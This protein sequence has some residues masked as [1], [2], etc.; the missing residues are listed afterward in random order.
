MGRESV[1]K[2]GELAIQ[3]HSQHIF[4]A[5]ITVTAISGT[6]DLGDVY[7]AII[8]YNFSTTAHIRI[9]YG[10]TSPSGDAT[11]KKGD[12][13]PTASGANRPGVLI[14]SERMQ[15][16]KHI[17]SVA[18]SHTVAITAHNNPIVADR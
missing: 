4:P 6:T 16:I 10:I 1:L 8:F 11:I 15:Y 7:D 9:I 17:A 18:G 12:V 13:I 14:L 5:D 2:D 3:G